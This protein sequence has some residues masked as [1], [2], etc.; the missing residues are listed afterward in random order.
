MIE[1]RID[2]ESPYGTKVGSGPVCSATNWTNEVRLDKAG[3]FSFDMLASDLQLS[4]IQDGRYA[5][6]YGLLGDSWQELGKP[7]IIKRAEKIIGPMASMMLRVSGPDLLHELAYRIVG[8]LKI[9][10]TETV[11]Y[12]E[13]KYYDSGGPSYTDKTVP[14]TTDL[15]QTNYLYIG[16]TTIFQGA[17][18]TMGDTKNFTAC[19]AN[20][21]Y[22]NGAWTNVAGFSDGTLTGGDTTL[23]QSGTMS[24][25]RPT[26]WETTDVNEDTAYWV[27][28]KSVGANTDQNLDI[29]DLDVLGDGPTTNG[30]ALI[31]AYAPS[32]WTLDTTNGYSVSQNEAYMFFDGETVLDALSMLARNTGEHFRL[33]AGRKVVWLQDDPSD[34]PTDCGVR[35]LPAIG[36]AE[37]TPN[38]CW[39]ESLQE[40]TDGYEQISRIYP[41][42]AGSGSD[43]ITLANATT[44]VPAGYT[45]SSVSIS[46]KTIYY[47][48][49]DATDAVA[50]IERAETWPEIAKIENDAIHNKHVSNMLQEV[51]LSYLGKRLTTQVAYSA[52]VLGLR[53]LVEPGES[54]AVKYWEYLD[55]NPV[56]NIDD[57]LV[58]LEAGIRVNPD[59][60]FTVALTLSTTDI[61]PVSEVELIA[62]HIRKAIRNWG[63]G[64]IWA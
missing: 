24:W 57:D 9:M 25:T 7:G 12:T 44:A 36:A 35:A 42:G 53:G 17:V 38:I 23:G 5:R 3:Q 47:I 60:I 1:I 62:A 50:Q 43:Q 64:A 32:G 11:S 58:I 26:D 14:F 21:E 18:F 4:E 16:Y 22:Y 46:D 39:I 19:T 37:S 63:S 45:R 29:T 20:V 59:G 41:V 49:H 48:K 27:R 8:P 51:A 61:W 15:T 30:P 13:C 54:M 55:G 52:M 31:M 28:I 33:G 34:N 6:C 2:I 10:A 40:I 56:V